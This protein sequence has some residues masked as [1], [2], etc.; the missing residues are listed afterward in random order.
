LL[1]NTMA[2]SNGRP[3]S[4][5]I[6]VQ[7]RTTDDSAPILGSD[8]VVGDDRAAEAL[9]EDALHETISK[10]MTQ[11]TRKNY[12]SRIERIIRYLDVSVPSYYAVGVRKITEE[13]KGD[14]SKY[15]FD[16]T[17]DLIY[18]GFNVKFFLFFLASEEVNKDGKL[19]GYDQLRKFRD[20]VLW[21]SKIAGQLLPSDFFTKSETY[22]IAFRRKFAQAK[23][24]GNVEEQATDPIPIPVYR[25]LLRRSIETN[26]I[27]AWT[28]TLLQWNCMARSASIDCL[29]FHNFSLGTDSLVVKYDDSKADK[30]GEKLSEKNLYANPLDWTMCPWL[31]LG[32]YFCVNCGN[33]GE[34]ERL[35][36][37]HG[38]KEG[39]SSTKYNEQMSSLVRGMENSVSPHM[40]VAKLNPYGLRKGAATH[41][42]SGT[43]AAPSIPSIARRGEWSIGSVLDVYWHFGSVGDH[44]LGRILCGLD[45][46]DTNFA[47]L[48]PHWKLEDPL[49]TSAIMEAMHLM[50]GP[51]LKEQEDGGGGSTTRHGAGHRS[52]IL[53]RCLASIV[54][55][56]KHL[57]ATMV[58]YPGHDFSK[59]AILHNPSLL[60]QL[61][62]LV[63]VEPTKGVLVAP[64]GIPPHV[65]LAVQV[66]EVL[67]TLGDLVTRFEEHGDTLMI[68]VEEAVERTALEGG[69]ITGDKLK[70]ILETHRRESLETV[71]QHLKSMREE[72]RAAIRQGRSDGAGAGAGPGDDD[73]GNLDFF[74]GTDDYD[75]C[76]GA[77]GGGGGGP[78]KVNRYM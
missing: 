41:A 50:Y 32:V 49:G 52:G 35:F 5:R 72:V 77:T 74:G 33:L 4:G 30:A 13:E 40:N 76:G 38:R 73:G 34:N 27:F 66:A 19:V 44:Y 47:V 43:T 61:K 25:F 12:R 39:I 55:H 68:A 24:V 45:P 53:L 78:T 31:G 75:T 42:V 21:G 16:R 37:K 46:N 8:L 22:L 69:H 56:S 62:E 36:L 7:N 17:E 54:F 20:A 28:W 51:I 9:L 10:G 15:Y 60:K 3:Q 23:K 18:S 64:T 26:N 2:R 11:Q 57:A 63:T 59:L 48:P 70:E 14:R 6:H 71:D 67:D 1:T 29:G 65:G 58:K